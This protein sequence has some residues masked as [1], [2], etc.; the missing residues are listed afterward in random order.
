MT[1]D[2]RMLLVMLIVFWGAWWVLA[3]VAKRSS[4]PVIPLVPLGLVAIGSLLNLLHPWAG[5]LAVAVL[6]LILLARM[7]HDA[8]RRPN[9]PGR[10]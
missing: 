7:T 1:S 8:V 9:Q 10:L 4:V 3:I 6:H 5:T 2:L